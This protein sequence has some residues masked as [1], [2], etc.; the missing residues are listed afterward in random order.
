MPEM[1]LV[2]LDEFITRMTGSAWSEDDVTVFNGPHQT[3]TSYIGR[4]ISVSFYTKDKKKLVGRMDIHS[5]QDNVKENRFW[6][7]S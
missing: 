4:F 6:V 5:L 7:S 1:K 3:E 2:P